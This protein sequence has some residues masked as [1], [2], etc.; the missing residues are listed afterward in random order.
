MAGT[1]YVKRNGH[2]PI[3]FMVACVFCLFF[4][5]VFVTKKFCR[6]YRNA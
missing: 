6:R 3:L 2:S 4:F 5:A 1:V